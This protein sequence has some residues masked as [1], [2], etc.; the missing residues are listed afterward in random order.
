ME[1]LLSGKVAIITGSNRGIG[2][3]I[4]EQFVRSGA[5]VYA[6]TRQDREEFRLWTEALVRES[7]RRVTHVYFDLENA[8]EMK[9]ALQKIFADKVPIDILVNNAAVAHGALFQMTS[10]QDLRRIFDINF[11]APLVMIQSVARQMMRHKK[12]SIINMASTAALA[13][14]QGSLAYASSKAALIQA[15][16]VMA[17]ELASSNI[18]V[19]AIAPGVT[20]TDMLAQMDSKA[21]ERIL[22]RNAIQRPALPKEIA[23]VAL[24]LASDLSSYMSGQVLRVDGAPI[25]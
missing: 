14:D 5:D 11:F 17:T 13:A 18:R 25:N 23:D 2:R 4:L 3:S 16:R 1:Q 22:Q 7:G 10:Q 21:I 9:V 6:C 12:G 8:T 15:T 20:Q 19:N 24:F